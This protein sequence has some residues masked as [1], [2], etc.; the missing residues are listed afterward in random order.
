M[1]DDGDGYVEC[2]I[3]ATGWV[4]TP[5]VVGGDD[6]DDANVDHHEELDWYFD[7][8][9]DGFGDAST[10][11]TVCVPHPM[12]MSWMAQT[13]TMTM[14]L[15]TPTPLKSA[16]DSSM[17]ASTITFHQKKPMT[18]GMDMLSAQSPPIF[19]TVVLGILGGDDCDDTS[20]DTRCR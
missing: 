8:D 11:F 19:G 9:S 18:M 16:M 20:S 17:T 2:T 1:D 12:D 15:P 14:A 10:G 5:S 13:A 4:G 6:C 3:D 7:N